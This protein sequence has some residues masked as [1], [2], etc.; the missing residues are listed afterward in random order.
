MNQ[1]FNWILYL[2]FTLAIPYVISLS[3]YSSYVLYNHK[4]ELLRDSILEMDSSIE[5][6][7]FIIAVDGLRIQGQGHAG[8]TL[9]HFPKEN[10]IFDVFNSFADT[11]QYSYKFTILS[12][13]F[14]ALYGCKK[15]CLKVNA[16]G[17]LDIQFMMPITDQSIGFI[18]LV[19]IPFIFF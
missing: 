1:K 2:N 8:E 7:D 12:T 11:I 18:E 13:V 10:A 3:R 15:T 19:V 4:N 9:I 6:L 5:R 17:L 14:K 16:R